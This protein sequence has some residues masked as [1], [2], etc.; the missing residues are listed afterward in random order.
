MVKMHETNDLNIGILCMQ[1]AFLEHK[2][3]LEKLGVDVTEVRR[4]EDLVNING[5]IL[6]GGESTTIGKLIIELGL[7]DQM[8]EMIKGG[9]PVWGTCAGLILLASEIKN[10][11]TIHLGLMDIVAV[12]NSYGRQLGSFAYNGSF[13][14]VEGEY[15]MVFIRAPHIHSVGDSVKVL[16]EVDGQI[17]AAKQDNILVTSFHPELTKD[18][19]IHE[20][21]VNSMVLNK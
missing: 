21:F 20:Y 2:Q 7:K 14:G 4:A 10:D 1:G 12:R 17:V 11:E 13:K 3:H 9:L 18:L 19:R 8:V 6:P 15:P 16:S 5:L